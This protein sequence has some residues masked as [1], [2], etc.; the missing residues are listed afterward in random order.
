MRRF[1]GR[2]GSRRPS[3]PCRR[4][5]PACGRLPTTPTIEYE[6]VR[7]KVH[8]DIRPYFR[9]DGASIPKFVLV[10]GAP[11]LEFFGITRPATAAAAVPHDEFYRKQFDKAM[12]DEIFRELLIWRANRWWNGFARRRRIWGA[13]LAYWAVKYGGGPAYRENGRR[14]YEAICIAP[15]LIAAL[16]SGAKHKLRILEETYGLKFWESPEA[17]EFCQ[18]YMRDNGLVDKDGR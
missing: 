11:C 10:F 4:L 2:G 8:A 14:Y 15:K 3:H 18:S 13:W 1:C 5:R 16:N 6:T 7:E 9:T 17:V 12:A